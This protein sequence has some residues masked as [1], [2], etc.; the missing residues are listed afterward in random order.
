MFQSIFFLIHTSRPYVW[1]L[2]VTK[3][4]LKLQRTYAKLAPIQNG[5]MKLSHHVS[6]WGVFMLLLSY[7]L[8]YT[9]HYQSSNESKLQ[10]FT[11]EFKI[12]QRNFY[13]RFNG[14]KNRIVIA[15]TVKRDES[16]W[17][18]Q[19][20]YILNK[21]NKWSSTKSWI[22]GRKKEWTYSYWVTPVAVEAFF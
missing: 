20:L 15:T 8:N 18:R 13:I 22:K 7:I 19:F 14:G 12:L 10:Q 4:R 9:I 1:L 21:T 6:L 17:R 16:R 5:C 11:L 3:K 2:T